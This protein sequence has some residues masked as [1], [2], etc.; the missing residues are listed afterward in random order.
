MRR[1]GKAS[2]PPAKGRRRSTVTPKARKAA[3]APASAPDLRG[4]VDALARELKEAREQQT[5]TAEVL[6]VMS[7]S[8]ADL[9]PVFETIGRRAEK[10]CDAQISLVSMVDGDLIRLAAI[11]GV[12]EK[13]V[14]AVRSVYYPMRLSDETVAARTIRSGAICHVPDVLSDPLY[15]SKEAARIAEFRACLG[16]PMIRDGQVVGAIFVA[17]KQPELFADAQVQLL[18]TFAAQA[19]IAIENTRL[20]NDLQESLQQQTATANV[21]KVI[22][23][24]AFDLQAVL[25]TLVKSAAQLC[26]AEMASMNRK[27]GETYRQVSSHGFS[28]D[29]EKY[30]LEHPVDLERGTDGRQ[31]DKRKEACSNCRCLRPIQISILEKWPNWVDVRSV[32]AVPILKEDDLIGVIAVYRHQ[33]RPFTD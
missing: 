26:E 4:P 10:L 9:T 1:S 19:V 29:F 18:K 17:R 2:G 13:G 27:F 7:T 30:M 28:P 6:K 32:A 31:G 15:P 23:R 3:A 16:V 12:T 21:L 22:S 5:A 33:V 8:L 11:S 24:S 20:L 25:N 14:E